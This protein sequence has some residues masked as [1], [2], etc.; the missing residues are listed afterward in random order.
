MTESLSAW[1]PVTPRG[2]ENLQAL[3]ILGVSL[4]EVTV[5][6]LHGRFLSK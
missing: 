6:K 2:K 4:I 1:A 3:V 5:V